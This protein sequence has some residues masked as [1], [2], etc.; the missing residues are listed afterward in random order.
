M[1][2][3]RIGSEAFNEASRVEASAGIH[4]FVIHLAQA[5]WLSKGVV[6]LGS[7]GACNSA[8]IAALAGGDRVDSIKDYTCSG[9]SRLR[10]EFSNSF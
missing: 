9:S 2:I 7:G 4:P 1:S 6:V 10:P 5:R 3:R 8:M